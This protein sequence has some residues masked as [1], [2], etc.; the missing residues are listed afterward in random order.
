VKEA[1]MV[2]EDTTTM[3]SQRPSAQEAG[4]RSLLSEFLRSRRARLRSEDVG[5]P[6]SR[7]RRVPG[8]RRE[9]VAI[10]AD[11]GI[12]WYT[13]LEQGRP[14]RMA[15]AT[16]ERVAD[17]LRL[18]RTE[19]A[20][21][22]GLVFFKPEAA[23]WDI[24]VP[25]GIAHIVRSYTA[26]PAF[27]RGP[28]W[29]VLAWNEIFSR[30][31]G[32]PGSSP[33]DRNALRHAFLDPSIRKLNVDWPALARQLVAA[34]RTDY[35]QHVGDEAFE[36]LIAELKRES[37]TFARLWR[38]S[39]VTSPTE[40]R[41]VRLQHPTLGSIFYDTVSLLIPDVPHATVVFGTLDPT[42]PEGS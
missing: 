12:T 35:A 42:Q 27:V 26:G 33:D 1:A 14:I 2:V 37:T 3:A 9:E 21:L 22:T 4:R 6:A 34:F 38:D 17:A 16:L 24:P 25:A 7:S 18:D 13:W 31:F 19:R 8:L 10:L 40:A 36:A 5:L 32:F 23:G 39:S 28:R 41:S 15:P 11:V 29:D 20:Y 30:I